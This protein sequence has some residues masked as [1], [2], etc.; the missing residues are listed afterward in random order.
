LFFGSTRQKVFV[1]PVSSPSIKTPLE[2][3][4]VKPYRVFVCLRTPPKL[5]MIIKSGAADRH[6]G[7]KKDGDDEYTT[8]DL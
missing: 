7:V 3:A 2:G 5:Q 1:L 8:D 6:S 4:G